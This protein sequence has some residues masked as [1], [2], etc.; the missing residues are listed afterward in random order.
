MAI[1]SISTAGSRRSSAHHARQN[2]W[3]GMPSAA[4]SMSDC[5]PNQAPCASE[6][7]T[8]TRV[9]PNSSRS[10]RAARR[11]IDQ[12]AWRRLQFPADAPLTC[13]RQAPIPGHGF[14]G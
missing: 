7:K 2:A 12:A 9:A 1:R 13:Q 4:R 3:G 6:P 8:T 14:R 11:A 5:G 10:S